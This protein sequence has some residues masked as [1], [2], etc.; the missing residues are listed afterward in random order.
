MEH[1]HRTTFCQLPGT[2]NDCHWQ[3]GSNPCP[4]SGN[5]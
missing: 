2:T 4:T 1:E 5:P 3:S